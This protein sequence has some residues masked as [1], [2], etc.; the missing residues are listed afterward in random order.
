MQTEIDFSH[1]YRSDDPASS[2]Q[3]AARHV[4]GGSNRTQKQI[5]LEAV[6]RWP[7]KTAAELTER[8]IMREAWQG[9]RAARAYHMVCRRLPDLRRDGQLVSGPVRK[10]SVNPGNAQTWD[11]A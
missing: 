8:I 11:L 4:R 3:S 5:V 10:C 2:R 7:G 1:L 9:M 6:E